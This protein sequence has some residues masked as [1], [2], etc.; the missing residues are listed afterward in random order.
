MA[1]VN[2][3]IHSK[4]FKELVQKELKVDLGK[5]MEPKEAINNVSRSPTKVKN[6]SKMKKAKNSKSP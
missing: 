6:Y 5:I 3:D 2:T 1:S 4:E